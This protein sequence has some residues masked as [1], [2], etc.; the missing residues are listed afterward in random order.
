M[1]GLHNTSEQ[2]QPMEPVGSVREQRAT[3]FFFECFR[4]SIAKKNWEEADVAS[5]GT[6][7]T[8]DLYHIHCGGLEA[9]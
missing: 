5:E 4:D 9:W 3:A 1:N 6:G 8:R 2:V 7:R